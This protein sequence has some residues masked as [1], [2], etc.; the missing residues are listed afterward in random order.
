MCIILQKSKLSTRELCYIALFTALIAALSQISIPMPIGLPMTLQTFIIPLAGVILG[1]KLG[2]LSVIA[3]ILLGVVGLP[4]FSGGGSG[5]GWLF[6]PTGG[7]LIG[8][9]FY[10][11]CAGLGAKA[12]SGAIKQH[13]FL[14]SGLLSGMVITYLFGMLQFA[15]VT[16]QT[17]PRAFS[18]V[19][20]QFLPTEIIKLIFVWILGK[21]IRN[22]L[23]QSG[24]LL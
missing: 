20:I 15:F 17:I 3:Y 24:L 10:A 18:V 11:L 22:L 6:G 23:A 7:F 8:F 2:I 14:A 19:V 1:A 21:K 16:D 9:P 4:V 5:F 12:E 13:Y